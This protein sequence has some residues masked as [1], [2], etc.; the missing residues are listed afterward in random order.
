QWQE[1]RDCMCD[2]LTGDIH[3][4]AQFIGFSENVGIKER[5]ADDAHS[6]TGH[7]LIDV[8]DSAVRPRLL[9]LLAVITYDLGIVGNMTWLE[10]WGYKLTLVTVEISFA[11]EDAITNRGTKG[12]MYCYPFVEVI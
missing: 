5:F 3:G 6:E 4:C 11:T 2:I 9:D 10:G 12:T 8:N 7:L 1:R